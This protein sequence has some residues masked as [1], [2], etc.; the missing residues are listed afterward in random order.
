MANGFDIGAALKK[1]IENIIKTDNLPLLL[2]TD[3]KS[4][5]ECL[6]K[7]G[8]THEKR[9]MVD[10]MCLRQSY[11]RREITEVIWI[12]GDSNPADAMT[13][14]RPCQAL[15]D[16]ID[17]NRI[18]LRATG[19]VERAQK[20]VIP[21]EKGDTVDS[22]VKESSQCL[23]YCVPPILDY[24][25]KRKPPASLQERTPIQ[26]AVN[27]TWSASDATPEPARTARTGSTNRPIVTPV[28][29]PRPR[30][31]ISERDGTSERDSDWPRG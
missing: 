25:C 18:S 11:E 13:K 15:R 30:D 31:G 10:I 26:G 28:S 27:T 24:P 9:L 16:L 23:T 19:W 7:L 12:D 20:E 6:V 14:S 5:Y 29:G 1:T 4:L 21:A 8:T 22:A 2:C 17:T 3:S